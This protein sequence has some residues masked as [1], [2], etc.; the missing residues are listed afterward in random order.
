[1]T[2]PIA[3]L[4]PNGMQQFIDIKGRPLVG[5]YVYYYIPG[6]TVPKTTW[7]DPQQLIPTTNP[8]VLDSRGQCLV[9]G[10]GQYRQV[11]KDQNFNTIWDQLT[12][13]DE[14]A[15]QIGNIGGLVFCADGSGSVLTTGV[16]RMGLCPFACTI[17]AW[18]VQG[19][20]SGSIV[21]DVWANTFV[22]NVPPTVLNS[23]CGGAFPTLSSNIQVQSANLSAWNIHLPANSSLIVNINSV[24]L[25]KK[26][27]LTLSVA[28][29]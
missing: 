6:T 8:V 22:N 5:G 1:M 10:N 26:C 7:H 9:Y 2:T 28:S 19:D 23:I 27:T 29:L 25:I 17:N 12:E 20:V 16:M 14:A 4:L 24:S 18:T 3:G 11:V 15:G 21:L 13:W